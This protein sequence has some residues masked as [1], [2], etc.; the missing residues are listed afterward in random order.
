M[1][2]HEMLRSVPSIGVLRLWNE[3][4]LANCIFTDILLNIDLIKGKNCNITQKELH[5]LDIREN[6][7]QITSQ[8]G[9]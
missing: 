2:L 4:R 3:T 1:H 6:Y 9:I 5:K 8:N 7:E